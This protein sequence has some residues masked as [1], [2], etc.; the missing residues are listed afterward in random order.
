M[1]VDKIFQSCD[2]RFYY[3]RDVRVHF[4]QHQDAWR[5]I[6]DSPEPQNAKLP[7]PWHKKLNHLEK[8]LVLRVLRPDKIVPAIQSFVSGNLMFG[9]Y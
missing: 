2:I 1:K 7:D 5:I 9:I 3:Y 6:F 4:C 8:I